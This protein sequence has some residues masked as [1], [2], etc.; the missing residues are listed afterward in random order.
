MND[1]TGYRICIHHLTFSFT[2]LMLQL[3]WQQRV[4]EGKLHVLEYKIKNLR[5]EIQT[6]WEKCFL[7]E[8]E[9]QEFEDYNSTDYTNRLYDC[10][11]EELERLKRK[12]YRNE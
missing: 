12:F 5:N 4:H 9:K 11:V 10:H 2:I 7:S 1:F 6:W 3:F 8:D